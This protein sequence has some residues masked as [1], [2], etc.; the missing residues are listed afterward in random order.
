MIARRL[1]ID[2]YRMRVK[3][4]LE[5]GE[6]YAPGESGIDSDLHIGLDLVSERLGYE[7]RKSGAGRGMGLAVGMKDAGGQMKPAQARLKATTDGKLF[8]HCGTIEVGQGVTSALTEIAA[9]VLR[10]PRDWVTYAEID[11]DVTPFDQGTRSSSSTTVMG[12]A[13]ERAAAALRD[14][15]LAFAAEQLG[16]DKDSLELDEWHVTRGN[17][18]V[19]V[20]DL[21]VRAFGWAGFDFEATGH[22]TVPYDASAPMNAKTLFWECSWAGAEVEV[23]DETGEIQVIRLVVSS[24]CGK[25]L[26]LHAVE[27]QDESNVIASLGQALFERLIYRDGTLVNSGPLTYRVPGP[28]DVPS[29]LELVVQEQGHGPGPFGAKGGGEGSLLTI[30]AAIANAVE[31][32]VGAR[33]TSLPLSPE[34]VLAAINA[35]IPGAA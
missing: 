3:N 10:V 35:R 27:G 8:L 17:E 9:R 30:A 18:R 2:P 13:I 32:A 5:L 11:T 31:D 26:N 12:K 16:C 6:P 29:G 34:N 19:P 4:M 14:N 20:R 24:D 28:V 22:F 1:G 21:I 7:K 33:V 23:D 25:A 15:V